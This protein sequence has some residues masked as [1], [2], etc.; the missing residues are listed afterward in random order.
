M[1]HVYLFDWGDTLMIDFPSQS[2][3]MYLW[4]HVEAVAESE[5][6]LK[7]L[8]QQHTIYVAT[9]AQ[10][11]SEAEIQRAFERVGLDSYINGYFCK[12]NLGLEK[13]SADFYLAILES[14]GDS[15]SQVTMVG[16]SL[17]KDI[18]PAIEAGLHAVYYNPARE[19]VPTDVTSIERLSQLLDIE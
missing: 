19:Y 3:K 1:S 9:S 15:A 6:T 13:N 5:Q 7:Q 12:A 18:Y 17:S 16:D 11:S 4:S 14:L 10:D 8:S 2:G